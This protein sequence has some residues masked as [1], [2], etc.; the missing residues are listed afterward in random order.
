M[1]K[2]LLKYMGIT[3]EIQFPTFVSSSA[4]TELKKQE[5]I[6][7]QYAAMLNQK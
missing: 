6:N 3:E 4:N 7:K 2:Q 1:S 5:E